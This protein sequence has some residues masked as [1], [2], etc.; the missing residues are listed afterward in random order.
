MTH[1]FSDIR[2]A[3]EERFGAACVPRGGEAFSLVLPDMTASFAP[4][5][6]APALVLVRT[7][8]LDTNGLSRKGGLALAALEGNF[9]W[10]GT[11]GATLSLGEDGALWLTERRPVEELSAPG[12]LGACLDEL[13]GTAA[14]WR[15][16]GS[17][18][19]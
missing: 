6:G 1:D 18:H 10:S 4:I 13:A 8:V 3:A 19:E 14:A 15:E 17:L 2:R 12:G 5:P 7:R 9:F 11:N 16:R